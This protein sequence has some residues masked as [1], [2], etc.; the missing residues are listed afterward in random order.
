M[1]IF[2]A[3]R[4]VVDTGLHAL[5]WTKEKAI[6]Y[7]TDHSA[8]SLDNIRREVSG[9]MRSFSTAIRGEELEVYIL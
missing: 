8:N 4:L 9:K 7:M 6:Q 2:R 3:C 5:G 1:E